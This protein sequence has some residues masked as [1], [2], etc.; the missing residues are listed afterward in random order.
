MAHRL[1]LPLAL[2]VAGLCGCSFFGHLAGDLEGA[3]GGTSD[4][5]CDRRYG[6]SETPQPF[7]Q[8]VV[9]TIAVSQ[10]GTDCTNHLQGL[11]TKGQCPRDATLLGGCKLDKSNEDG[12]HTTDWYYDVDALIDAGET[13]N[14]GSLVHDASDVK[15]ICSSPS[16]YSSPSATFV[17]P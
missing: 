10:F 2:V 8:E 11:Y 15:A 7:C 17:D 14:P 13:F 16:H 5:A 3:F 9:G 12:S 6:A 1:G 4:G